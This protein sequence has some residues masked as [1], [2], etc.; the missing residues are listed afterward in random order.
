MLYAG[1]KALY[2]YDAVVGDHMGILT[3]KGNYFLSSWNGYMTNFSKITKEG[4]SY[5][6]Y[7]PDYFV[8]GGDPAMRI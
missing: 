2:V 3:G 7:Q 4:E 8:G 6:C 5:S 1:C